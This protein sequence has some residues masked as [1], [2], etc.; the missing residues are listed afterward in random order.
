[1]IYILIALTSLAL[2]IATTA[3]ISQ[4]KLVRQINTVLPTSDNNESLEKMLKTYFTKI[5][6]VES[7]LKRSSKLISFL[8]KSSS[9][10][11]QK[12]GLVRFNPFH[13]TGGDHS[14]ALCLLDVNDCGVIITGI[15]G[16]GG[17]RIYV[18]PIEYGQSNLS[19][20]SEEQ[21]ACKQA[22]RG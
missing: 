19:L 7:D 15:H 6:Q 3:V 21:K 22:I 14:F 13:D 18:K 16:R 8:E 5:R 9:R 11:L 12:I 2:V 17:T 1:M 4:K 20:S 10:S